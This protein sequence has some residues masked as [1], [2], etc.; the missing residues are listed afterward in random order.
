VPWTKPE[1]IEFDPA[2]PLP[3][4]T[5]VWKDRRVTVAFMDGSIRDLRLG[6]DNDSWRAIITRNGGEEVDLRKLEGK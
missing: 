3:K 1:D 4:L 5:S 2:A 6:I